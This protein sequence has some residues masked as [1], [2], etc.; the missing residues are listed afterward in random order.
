MRAMWTS[1]TEAKVTTLPPACYCVVI[2][3]AGGLVPC[4]WSS[5][6][7]VFILTVYPTSSQS[8]AVPEFFMHSTF[9]ATCF[10]GPDPK[11]SVLMVF[12]GIWYQLSN[13]TNECLFEWTKNALNLNHWKKMENPGQA[14][15]TPS[16]DNSVETLFVE[17]GISKWILEDWKSTGQQVLS[18]QNCHFWM[19]YK[20]LCWANLSPDAYHLILPLKGSPDVLHLNWS[21]RIHLTT[22]SLKLIPKWKLKT[23]YRTWNVTTFDWLITYLHIGKNETMVEILSW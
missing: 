7:W 20:T 17:F 19:D 15:I 23:S 12:Q 18:W 6:M 3:T 9:G 22:K 2:V 13:E 8:N 11:P 16:C 4:F 5:Q 14:S 21:P 1:Y 10:N